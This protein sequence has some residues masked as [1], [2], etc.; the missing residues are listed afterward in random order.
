MRKTKTAIPRNK[1]RGVLAGCDDTSAKSRKTSSQ[2]SQTAY[3]RAVSS[4]TKTRAAKPAVTK[5]T[6]RNKN[7]A[8]NTSFAH[9][10]LTVILNTALVTMVALC[11]LV[12]FASVSCEH[13]A[14]IAV[15]QSALSLAAKM[16][17]EYQDDIYQSAQF[18]AAGFADKTSAPPLANI[19]LEIQRNVPH[20]LIDG[21]YAS[22]YTGADWWT[23]QPLS[24]WQWVEVNSATARNNRQVTL[25]N[26]QGG[27]ITVQLLGIQTIA[28]DAPFGSASQTELQKCL[29]TGAHSKTLRV[30]YRGNLSNG[31]G[32]MVASN[33][34]NCALELLKEGNAH[35]AIDDRD[36]LPKFTAEVLE[37]YYELAKNHKKGMFGI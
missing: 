23:V 5:K 33:G 7:T 28:T 16:L 29:D 13:K 12:T 35:F 1:G 34:K 22:N 27:T 31:S 15:K 3:K 4:A 36:N 2:S 25:Y 30:Y 20:L 17:P 10:V 8:K 37:N 14:C 26:N 18:V 21:G 9:Q 19:N 32:V 6:R 11:A 24:D